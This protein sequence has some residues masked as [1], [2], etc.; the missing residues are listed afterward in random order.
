[1]LYLLHGCCGTYE[2][3]TIGSDIEELTADSDLLVVMPDGGNMGFYSDWRSGPGW[4]TFHL[5]ELPPILA[6]EF[7][8]S[9]VRAVAGLSMGGFGALAYA[10][11]HPGMFRATASFSGLVHTTFSS[12]SVEIV[13]GLVRGYGADPEDLWGDLTTD[14]ATWT[15]HNPYDLATALKGTPVFIS[16]G[17]GEPGP[18]DPAGAQPDR[19]E[20]RLAAQNVAFAARLANV[21]VDAQVELHGPGTHAW[22]YWSRELQRAWPMFE[23]ALGLR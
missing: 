20:A 1:V 18:L 8:A 11:R 14:P 3:W 10:A 21:G 5:T 6:R 12:E 17:T 2:S 22:P 9:E 15:A 19:T 4:E 23:Q 7:R 13:R 16:C